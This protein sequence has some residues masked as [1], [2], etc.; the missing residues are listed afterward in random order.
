[1]FLTEEFSKENISS[2]IQELQANPAAL[3]LLKLF[4][5]HQ[6][7]NKIQIC[8]TISITDAE[9]PTRLAHVTTAIRKISGDERDHWFHWLPDTTQWTIGF[10]LRNA[11][12][13]EFGMRVTDEY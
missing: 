3:D 12:R 5:E 13:H 6:I 1:M 9:V 4:A 2:L 10:G 11:L 7:V 8:R